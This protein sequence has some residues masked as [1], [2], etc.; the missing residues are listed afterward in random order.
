MVKGQLKYI[1]YIFT[2][3]LLE[4][5]ELVGWRACNLIC[6]IA[7]DYLLLMYCY[8]KPIIAYLNW[9]EI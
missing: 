9:Y 2:S 6:E 8:A 1:T 3:I 5:L 4:S 7:Q